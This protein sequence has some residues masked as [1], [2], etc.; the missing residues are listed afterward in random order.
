MMG[1]RVRHAVSGAR[2]MPALAQMQVCDVVGVRG[3]LF[4]IV[5]Q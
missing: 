1:R 5:H 3:V 4:W 2:P